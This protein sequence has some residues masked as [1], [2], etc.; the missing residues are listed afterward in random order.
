[1]HTIISFFL[2]GSPNLWPQHV[3]FVGT[4]QISTNFLYILINFFCFSTQNTMHFLI[5][6]ILWIETTFYLPSFD[7]ICW[8][9]N[10]SR[11]KVYSI[12]WNCWISNLRQV[13]Q[14]CFFFAK[15]IVFLTWIAVNKKTRK[16]LK[17]NNQFFWVD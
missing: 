2:N 14:T 1:M 12:V 5:S 6:I 3:T 4:P 8:Q 9:S 17:S 11:K 13:F 15:N 16:R 7:I 10:V